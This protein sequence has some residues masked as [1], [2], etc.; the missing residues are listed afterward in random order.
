M[1][2]DRAKP[3]TSNL[4]GLPVLTP[5]T[6]P[7]ANFRDSFE[8]PTPYRLS[9]VRLNIRDKCTA[10]FTA[11]VHGPAG[12][13]AWVRAWISNEPDGTLAQ[14]EIGAIPVGDEVTLTVVLEREAT[15]TLACMR[16]ESERL[17][18]KHTVH[19][20]LD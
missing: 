3:P 6:E 8:P 17:A 16:I 2:N 14:A 18:T 15:P 7:I 4:K 19:H 1:P 12:S 11:N 5:S 20:E 9:D 10:V 13:T